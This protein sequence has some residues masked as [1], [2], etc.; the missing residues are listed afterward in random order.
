M[1]KITVLTFRWVTKA[2][3][4]DSKTLELTLISLKNSFRV[5]EQIVINNVFKLHW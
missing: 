2:D 3:K 1:G 4:G 5:S